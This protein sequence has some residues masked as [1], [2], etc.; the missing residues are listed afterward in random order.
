MV[1]KT[2]TTV[3]QLCTVHIVIITTWLELCG[4]EFIKDWPG[5]SPDISPIENLWAIA[6]KSEAKIG[7]H[8]NGGEA[9]RGLSR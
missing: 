9:S 8:L 2:G 1:D 4:V 6:N 3:F 7:G 5:N